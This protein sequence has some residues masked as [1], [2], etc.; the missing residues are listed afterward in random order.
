MA[1]P[2]TIRI[3]ALG[4]L[5][6][7]MSCDRES[8]V[9]F[10]DLT[11]DE[12]VDRAAVEDK[13]VFV[14]FFT[15]WCVPCKEMD[16]TTF[17]DARV[18][19]WLREHTVA[20]KVDAEAH[21][22]LAERYGVSSYPNYVFVSAQG[23]LLDRL[24]G[25]RTPDQLIDAGE[26]VRRGENA[27]SR[28]KSALAAGNPNDPML[29]MDLG[30]AYRAMGQDEAALTEYLWCFD[31]GEQH[32]QGFH[33]VRLSFLLSRIKRLGHRYP[34]AMTALFE[35]R[36]AAEQRIV[37]GSAE[38]DDISVF[39]S[40]NRALDENETTIAL[41]DRVKEAG[42][43]SARTLEA[44]A[45]RCFD[46]LA[47]AKRYE[48]IVAEYD[49]VARVDQRFE[50]Y[51]SVM[52]SLE[53]P[54][55]M[56]E[57]AGGAISDEIRNEVARI[58]ADEDMQEQIRES[59]R[60]MLRRGVASAYQVLIGS[61]L[62]DEAEAVA[63]RLVGGLDDAD[64]RNALAWAG[65]LTGSPIDANVA[66]AREAFAMTG[67]EDFAIV[68]TLARVLAIR[69]ELDEAVAVAQSGL[70]RAK[71]DSDRERMQACLAFLSRSGLDS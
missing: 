48:R 71:T 62:F 21:E 41:Y 68:D 35:R 60:G 9:Q 69:G 17:Q 38:Y 16:A 3:L 64:T 5:L 29:R 34:P 33:G 30:D 59:Q 53:D 67:G 42:R 7:A 58:A 11:F 43:L 70:E 31:E 66:Q 39:S 65:Y 36:R 52:A 57:K 2:T 6:L 19:A 37:D 1:T 27:V 23:E 28:A 63:E 12:A 15:T 54:D 61:G 13:L 22:T 47:D 14:D 26:S 50:L 4:G 45:N 44:F 32:T 10:H 56:L 49:V 55:A 24:T 18:A 51:E 8:G 46:L 20:L 40:I 25:K